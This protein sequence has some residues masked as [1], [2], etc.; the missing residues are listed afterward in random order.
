MA[1]KKNELNEQEMRKR[2]NDALRRLL[3]GTIS[4]RDISIKRI[5]AD[6]GVSTGVFYYY[7]RNKDE[8]LMYQFVYMDENYKDF[9][10]GWITYKLKTASLWKG[11]SSI[12]SSLWIMKNFVVIIDWGKVIVDSDYCKIVW[13]REKPNESLTSWGLT[14]VH[15]DQTDIINTIHFHY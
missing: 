4:Y 8:A 7:Y 13:K 3:D 12:F 9:W 6:A 11:F 10:I 15:S 2:L 14:C 1:R 5:C